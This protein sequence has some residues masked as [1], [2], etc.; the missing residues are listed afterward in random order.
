MKKIVVQDIDILNIDQIQNLIQQKQSIIE[1]K[2]A[3]NQQVK[4]NIINIV[5]TLNES[6]DNI[7]KKKKNLQ[8]VV[9]SN[10]RNKTIDDYLRF[11]FEQIR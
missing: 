5:Q 1:S 9:L 6:K 11:T 2:I 4:K 8:T 3:K 10:N 7:M